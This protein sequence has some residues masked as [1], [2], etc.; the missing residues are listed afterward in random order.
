MLEIVFMGIYM[1]HASITF[2]SKGQ[3]Q[4]FLTG[5]PAIADEDCLRRYKELVRTQMY[6]ALGVLSLIIP[7]VVISVILVMRHGLIGLGLVLAANAWLF[8]LGQYHKRWEVRAR[9]L[10]AGSDA[11]RRE[12]H[13]VSEAWVKKPLPTF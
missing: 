8:G 5:T 6:L 7:G 1:V 12:Y 9:G 4:A 10:E 3:L 13:E 11:L 2:W